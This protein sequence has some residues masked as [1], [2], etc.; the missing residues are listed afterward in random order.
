MRYPKF[1]DFD[2]RLRTFECWKQLAD[3]VELSKSGLFYIGG[4]D[5]V[6]CFNCAVVLHTWK[7]TDRADFE[8]IRHSP[9]CTFIKKKC[10]KICTAR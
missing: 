7:P 6:Q 4:V 2:M 3:P 8:H 9:N 1:S 5:Q 10:S